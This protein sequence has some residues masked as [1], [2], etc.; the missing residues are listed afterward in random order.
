M[1]FIESSSHLF[2]FC[3]KGFRN[4]MIINFSSKQY[5]PGEL[6]VGHGTHIKEVMLIVKGKV[7]LSLMDNTTFLTMPKG[8][9]MGEYQVIENL[10]SNIN[11]RAFGNLRITEFE[12]LETLDHK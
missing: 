7:N 2:D 1:P 4:E 10:K 9:L 8:S 5:N 12:L 3:E 11:Y 6:I